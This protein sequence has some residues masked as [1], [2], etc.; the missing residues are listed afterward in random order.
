MSDRFILMMYAIGACFTVA[1][2]AL[3]G[4]KP[5]VEVQVK[6]VY[7]E[8]AEVSVELTRWQLEK[9]LG[10]FEPDAHPSDSHEFSTII[11]KDYEG[12]K[13]SSTHLA[14]VTH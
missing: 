5:A 2:V 10:A 14:R 11:R 7:P 9:M 4:E 6:E 3:S 1:M 13:L 12:W 8:N